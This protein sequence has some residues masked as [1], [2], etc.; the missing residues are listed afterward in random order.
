MPPLRTLQ[1]PLIADEEAEQ[2][3]SSRTC[4][5]VAASQRDLTGILFIL[6][7]EALNACVNGFVKFVAAWPTQRLML[8]RFTADLL[9]SLAVIYSRGL[10]FPCRVD[11]PWLLARGAAYCAG[12]FF[13]WAALQ[14]CLP[15]GDVVVTVI[16]MAPLVL[17]LLSR[18]VLHESI[19]RTWLPQML[20]CILGALLINKPMA[21]AEGCPVATE[22]APLGAAFFWSLMNLAVRRCSH[23]PP[24]LISAFTDV[25]A[26]GFACVTAL[27]ATGGDVSAATAR[28]MPDAWDARLLFA[29]LAALA[30]WAGTQSNIAGYQAVSVAVVASVAGSTSVPFNYALQI[31]VFGELP[32]WL[33]VLGA[34]LIAT[35]NVVVTVAKYRAAASASAAP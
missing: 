15:V 22:L 4:S 19:P 34:S 18:L 13:F 25:T 14:S 24:P 11:V 20:L 32:D 33:S 7:S 31:V 29:L 30:G 1:K 35:T 8:V 12:L 23:V 2:A 5:V 17:A 21:P 27:A 16:A 6:A 26:I 28:L 10:S 9:I 3:G